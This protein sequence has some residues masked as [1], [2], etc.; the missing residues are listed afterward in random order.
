[1]EVLDA[2]GLDISGFWTHVVLDSDSYRWFSTSRGSVFKIMIF[3]WKTF[4]NNFLEIFH[5]VRVLKRK[6]SYRRQFQ[7]LRWLSMNM[8]W[9]WLRT[10][11]CL[12]YY[13]DPC[14]YYCCVYEVRLLNYTCATLCKYR[15]GSVRLF[16]KFSI[17][18][19]G[20]LHWG[21]DCFFFFFF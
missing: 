20:S 3:M 14:I 13:E 1:M 15:W 7:L 21:Q 8:K 10:A 9:M 6:F 4:L 2:Q 16:Q 19:A 11:N 12:M 5:K 18:V 17:F